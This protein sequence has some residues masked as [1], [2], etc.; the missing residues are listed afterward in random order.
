MYLKS[1][2]HRGMKEGCA[3]HCHFFCSY[4]VKMSHCKT[5]NIDAGIT[6]DFIKA[7]LESKIKPD[8][9]TGGANNT[10]NTSIVLCTPSEQYSTDTD[11][12]AQALNIMIQNTPEQNDKDMMTWKILFCSKILRDL[13]GEYQEFDP[14]TAIDVYKFLVS[15]NK[16]IDVQLAE[17]TTQF[18]ER[19]G[20]RWKNVPKNTY[21]FYEHHNAD[22]KLYDA[23]GKREQAA[24]AVN[25]SRALKQNKEVKLTL[26]YLDDKDAAAHTLEIFVQPGQLAKI[27]YYITDIEEASTSGALPWNDLGPNMF[28]N[29]F[30][31]I[32]RYFSKLA[33]R[34]PI[35]QQGGRRLPYENL[36][37]KELQQRCAKRKIKYSGLRKADLIAALRA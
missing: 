35:K 12:A 6:L 17:A 20:P 24:I 36:T 28:E 21:R 23:H 11:I 18:K 26:T 19:N 30:K 13:T 32:Q 22:W 29:Y 8:F 14:D 10:R 4:S 15:Q 27:Q 31:V 5:F 16:R 37:V 7:F 1:Q 3:A 9:T 34:V 2:P 33:K 25:V